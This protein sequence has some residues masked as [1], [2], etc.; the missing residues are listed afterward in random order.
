[1]THAL[2]VDL[3]VVQKWEGLRVQA[4]L[5]GLVLS[6]KSKLFELSYRPDQKK[7][8]WSRNLNTLR[9]VEMYLE[10]YEKGHTNGAIDRARKEAEK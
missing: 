10:A 8:P 9:E 1:M 4:G 7:P 6:H 5:L 3:N 2:T